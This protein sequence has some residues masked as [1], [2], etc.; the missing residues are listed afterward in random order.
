MKTIGIVAEYNPFHLGHEYHIRESRRL[1]GEE[2][3][4]VAVMSGDFVQ[5]GEAAA[6]SK[7]ARAEAACRC[8]A[9]L[10]IEL[11]LPWSIASAEGFAD[12]AVQ[13]LAALGADTLSFGCETTDLGELEDIASLLTEPT[14]LEETKELLKAA[15]ARSYASARQEATERRLGRPLAVLQQPNSILA[16]EYLKA[17][18]RHGFSLTPL[19]IL[20]KGAGH[21][22]TGEAE[23]LLSA[24]ELRRRL[25]TGEK[26][27]DF[28]P[29]EAT[30]VY[31]E[32]TEAGRMAHDRKRQ[33]LLMLSRLRFLKEEDYLSLPDAGDGLGSRI[34]SAVKT[35]CSYEEIL[36]S[37]ATRRFPLAR[38]RRC[39][40]AAALGVNAGDRLSA[41]PYARVLAFDERG[42]ALLREAA[43][44]GQIPILTKT[45][46]VSGLE[47][48]AQR[49]F[50]LGARAHD[51]YTLNYRKEEERSCGEDWRRGPAVCT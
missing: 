12:G 23:G 20:R 6:F 8:G 49:V 35:A 21:D 27:E 11:P 40:V 26:T 15:P 16:L 28:M 37:A 32:E 2:S 41:V 24:S 51:F 17:V 3:A 10:V 36:A 9:D 7:H 13:L 30:A 22:E 5:R 25:G 33:D 39:C 19:P 29:G 44:R 46:H 48:Q 43:Q 50:D 4:V 38:V 1:A 45:A 18:H 31:A 14:F 34:W 47:E 42:R